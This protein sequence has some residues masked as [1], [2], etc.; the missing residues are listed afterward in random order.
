MEL[1]NIIPSLISAVALIV[2]AVIETRNG[3][4]QTAIEKAS[5]RRAEESQLS[6][7]MMDASVALALDTAKA[8]R[9]GHT[10]G[11]LEGNIKNAETSRQN[12]REFLRRTASEAINS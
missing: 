9:D 2:V 11:T 10:N 12:Y 3:K 5:K 7:A 8:L 6:M 4:R 1:G